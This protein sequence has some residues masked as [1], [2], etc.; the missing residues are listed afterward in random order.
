MIDGIRKNPPVMVLGFA[1]AF[2]LTGAAITAIHALRNDPTLLL[3]NKKENPYPWLN[4]SQGTNIKFH[5]VNQKFDASIK[6]G[7]SEKN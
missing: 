7:F 2:G 4:V 6:K 5:A 3:Y 1:I